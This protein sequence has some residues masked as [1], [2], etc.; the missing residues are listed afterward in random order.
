MSD[1][2]D[3]EPGKRTSIATLAN[4]HITLMLLADLMKKGILIQADV[5]NIADS[6]PEGD[7]GT[8]VRSALDPFLKAGQRAEDRGL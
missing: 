3:I 2:N 4:T 7:V 5:K 8:F 6:A 1:I